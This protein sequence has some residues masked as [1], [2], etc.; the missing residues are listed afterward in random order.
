MDAM[1]FLL[2]L[3]T[4]I[5]CD[6]RPQDRAAIVLLLR[7]IRVHHGVG[8]AQTIPRKVDP[9]PLG[10]REI[11]ELRRAPMG[12]PRGAGSGVFLATLL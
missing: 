5:R 4:I 10:E 2:V 9:N 6:R 7:I 3:R 8:C 1:T 12:S 11:P